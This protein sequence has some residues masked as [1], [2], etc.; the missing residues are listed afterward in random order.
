MKPI[1]KFKKFRD[2]YVIH[3]VE[4]AKLPD[5]EDDYFMRRRVTFHGRVQHIGFRLELE[6]MATRLG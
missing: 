6:Q 1:D 3:Q 5:F 4:K 2:D